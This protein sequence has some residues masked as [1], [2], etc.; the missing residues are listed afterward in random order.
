M[1]LPVHTVSVACKSLGYEYKHKLPFW[2]VLATQKNQV[3]LYLT[4]I[5]LSCQNKSWK[6]MCSPAGGAI[7]QF[8]HCIHLFLYTITME[9]YN[10]IYIFI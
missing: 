2:K 5:G 9:Y 10:Y 3:K 7:R 4:N 6:S 8:Y 1:L